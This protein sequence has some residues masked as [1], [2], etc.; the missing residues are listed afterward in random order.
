MRKVGPG[1]CG[2]TYSITVVNSLGNGFSEK[3]YRCCYCFDRNWKAESALSSS[4]PF[5][6]HLP[7]RPLDGRATQGLAPPLRACAC[8]FSAGEFDVIHVP[9]K[10]LWTFVSNY[11]YYYFIFYC[12]KLCIFGIIFTDEPQIDWNKAKKAMLR[13]AFRMK[14]KK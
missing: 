13:Q 1:S 2:L 6:M 14:Q 9:L 8:C 10:L 4:R 5:C 3:S 11:E 7:K 12:K